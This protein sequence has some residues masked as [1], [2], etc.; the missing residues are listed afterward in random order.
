MAGYINRT[1]LYELEG[2]GVVHIAVRHDTRKISARWKGERLHVN[3]PV[4]I[5]VDHLLECLRSFGDRLMQIR[6]ARQYDIG[7]RWKFPHFTVTLAGQTIRQHSVMIDH[8][9]NHN[10]TLRIHTDID[11]SS[12]SG[13]DLVCRGICSVAQ[14]YGRRLLARAREI[15]RMVRKEPLGWEISRGRRTLGHCN[16]RGVIALS[17][18]LLLYPAELA[19]AVVCHE[20]AHLTEM[21]HSAA[22]HALCDNYCRAVTGQ[23][24]SALFAAIKSYPL[25]VIK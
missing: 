20:L 21:N 12:P 6:P 17:Y 18:I 14:R 19:D 11:L 25:P 5:S 16:A 10:Y 15:A 9:D 3:A 2:F 22:F 24:E 13:C 8:D 4:G 1:G 7:Q 23:T